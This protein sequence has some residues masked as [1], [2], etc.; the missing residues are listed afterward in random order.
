FFVERDEPK[1]TTS[2][3]GIF[4]A[5]VEP[6]PQVLMVFNGHYHKDREPGGS[7]GEYHQ[8]S[9]NAS[10]SEVF[11]MLSHYQWMSYADAP[12]WIRLVEVRAGDSAAHDRVEDS[13]FSPARRGTAGEVRD[14]PSSSF[15][16]EID[17]ARR[18]AFYWEGLLR[19]AALRRPWGPEPPRCQLGR[20]VL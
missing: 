8:V 5:L 3:A 12:D 20:P 6:F 2:G 18:F 10:G 11:E 15:G 13:T 7:R 14:V 19:G 4:T 17:F 16:F 1:V 9:A